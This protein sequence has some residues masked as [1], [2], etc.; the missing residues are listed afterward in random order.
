MESW[1]RRLITDVEAW[2]T[3]QGE[4]AALGLQKAPMVNHDPFTK[5]FQTIFKQPGCLI[6]PN[7]SFEQPGCLTG[8]ANLVWW[9]VL[10]QT[11]KVKVIGKRG[12]LIWA[13]SIVVLILRLDRKK[14]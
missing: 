8:V 10:G 5:L 12:R 14:K 4:L 1:N 9:Q 3:C 6:V 2:Y 13:A 11:R 7:N